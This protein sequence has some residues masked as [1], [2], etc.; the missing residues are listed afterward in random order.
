MPAVQRDFV[1]KYYWV[2]Q[3]DNNSPRRWGMTNNKRVRWIMRAAMKRVRAARGM[4]MVMR[5]TGDKEG[6][7]NGNEG[8]GQQR[9]RGCQGDGDGSKG[10]GGVTAMV[11]KREMATVL[12]TRVVDE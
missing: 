6:K 1:L 3:G 2:G 10:G 5:M 4:I 9:G 8:G 12:A 7:G 11:R